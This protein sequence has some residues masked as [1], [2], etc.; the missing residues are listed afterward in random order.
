MQVARDCN[1]AGG[2]DTLASRILGQQVRIG[3]PLRVHGL[4]LSATGPEFA[5]AVGLSLFAA[6]PQDEWWDFEI[7]V[8]RYPARSLRRAVRWFRDNW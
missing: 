3:R 2:L 8:D 4:P 5:S 7:P 1:Q 6:H